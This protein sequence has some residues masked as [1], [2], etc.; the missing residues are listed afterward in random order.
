MIDFLS[1]FYF[2][3]LKPLFWRGAHGRRKKKEL[4]YWKSQIKAHVSDGYSF[5]LTLIRWASSPSEEMVQQKKWIL[6]SKREEKDLLQRT[7][8]GV[9]SLQHPGRTGF[10]KRK[11][12]DLL[13]RQTNKQMTTAFLLQ[14]ILDWGMSQP[15]R[16]CLLKIQIPRPWIEHGD[17]YF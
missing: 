7:E 16:G 3:H 2:M 17:L 9:G 6:M 15:K 12:E 8:L 13:P 10:K 4:R 11:P 14:V 1:L 5:P